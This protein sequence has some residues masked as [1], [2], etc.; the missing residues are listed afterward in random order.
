MNAGMQVN[1]LQEQ[2]AACGF[3]SEEIVTL[4]RLQDWYQTG[5]SDRMELV[6]RW[7]FLKF[8][9]RNGQLDGEEG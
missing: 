4:F 6:R 8:L 1:A 5:G 7:E 9:V 2:L 3:T